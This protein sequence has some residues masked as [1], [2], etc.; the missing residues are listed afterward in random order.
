MG[1]RG[2]VCAAEL[3][4]PEEEEPGFLFVWTPDGCPRGAP[5][6]RCGRRS[7]GGIG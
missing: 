3:V 1:A 6:G 5:A 2:F 4:I 7:A